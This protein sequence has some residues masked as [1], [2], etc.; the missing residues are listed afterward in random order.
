MKGA[1]TYLVILSTGTGNSELVVPGSVSA[2]EGAGWVWSGSCWVFSQADT[3]GG[4]GS[5]G[6]PSGE[7]Q[8]RRSET[9]GELHDHG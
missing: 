4:R 9:G 5:I 2:S 3:S 1:E 6:Q 8:D 7:G